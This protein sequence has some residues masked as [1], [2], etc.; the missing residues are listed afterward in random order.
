MM[1]GQK[2]MKLSHTQFTGVFTVHLV[3][4]LVFLDGSNTFYIYIYMFVL[5][6][7]MYHINEIFDNCIQGQFKLL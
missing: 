7:I 6:L 2:N 5:S 3:P 4:I 1:H